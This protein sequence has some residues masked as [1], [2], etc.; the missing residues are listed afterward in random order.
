MS[1]IMYFIV[2]TKF[3]REIFSQSFSPTKKHS[4]IHCQNSKN[5]VPLNPKTLFKH[6][7]QNAN[8]VTLNPLLDVAFILRLSVLSFIYLIKVLLKIKPHFASVHFSFGCIIV[9]H[10]HIFVPEFPIF[11]IMDQNSWME[12][13]KHFK[14]QKTFFVIYSEFRS[15]RFQDSCRY[16]RALSN[17]V[18]AKAF[19]LR[20]DC[21]GGIRAIHVDIILNLSNE[22]C[23]TILQYT[24]GQRIWQ[25]LV[26]VLISTDFFTHKIEFVFVPI[27]NG[28]ELAAFR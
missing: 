13:Q 6:L 3:C 25:I 26:N 12:N 15:F 4:Y 11:E 5:S 1:R 8:D 19:L 21:I 2:K 28:N 18:L 10:G 27:F 7:Y 17:N 23:N 24:A 16:F 14:I 22:E 20:F 9:G